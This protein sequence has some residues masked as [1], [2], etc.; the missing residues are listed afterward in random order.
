MFGTLFRFTF[1]FAMIAQAGYATAQTYQAH[2]CDQCVSPSQMQA[3]AIQKRVGMTPLYVYNLSNQTI[4]KFWVERV[5]SGGVPL[6]NTS[7][8]R[9]SGI[10]TTNS[11]CPPNSDY[12]AHPLPVEPAVASFFADVVTA[13]QDYGNSLIG[14]EEIHYSELEPYLS[15]SPS[16][17]RLANSGF[18][19]EPGSAYEFVNNG[20]FSGSILGSYNSVLDQ[21]ANPHTFLQ[22]MRNVGVSLGVVTVDFNMQQAIELRSK[23]TF[24]DGSYVYIDIKGEEAVYRLGS[25]RDASGVRIP[26]PSYNPITGVGP[27]GYLSGTHEPQSI[28]RWCE[29]LYMHLGISCGGAGGGSLLVGCVVMHG[30]PLSCTRFN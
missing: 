21:R 26:D 6:G 5:C 25:A 30:Q 2:R 18:L 13:Y 16:W 8:E 9:T 7:P 12:M 17:Q 14:Y 28:H 10:S 3:F 24:E 27:G 11:F 22:L 20:N 4:E 19:S 1:V 29:S 23:F 15:E